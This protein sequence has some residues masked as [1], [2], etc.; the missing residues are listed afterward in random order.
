MRK[1]DQVTLSLTTARFYQRKYPDADVTAL[2]FEERYRIGVTTI[3]LLPAGH[4]LG[5]AQICIEVQGLRVIYTGDVKLSASFTAE[6]VKI[7]PCDVLIIEST[8]GEPSYVF[9][10]REEVAEDLLRFV[11]GCFARR[12]TPVILAYTIGKAQEAVKVLGDAG[13]TC[14]LEKS[15][16]D[17]TEI[18]REL[19]VDLINYRPFP[20]FTMG[21]LCP[22]WTFLYRLRGT[23]VGI[24][25]IVRK[26]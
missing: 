2:A 4:I 3:E 23:G 20:P 12:V 5:S 8:Y 15:I 22:K 9:P 7:R 18:Y 25:Q 1:H 11:R 16:F 21:S 24:L 14:R 17:A 10:K 13:I 6:R 26:T 19:G